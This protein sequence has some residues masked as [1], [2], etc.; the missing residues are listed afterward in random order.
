MPIGSEQ[1]TFLI[2]FYMPGA[3][4]FVPGQGRAFLWLLEASLGLLLLGGPF[5]PH[6]DK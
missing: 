6:T 2:A 1:A 4:R 5:Q 3:D